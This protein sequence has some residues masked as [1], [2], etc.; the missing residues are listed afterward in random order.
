FLSKDLPYYHKMIYRYNSKPSSHGINTIMDY[1]RELIEELKEVRNLDEASVINIIP[2]LTL[3]CQP[4]APVGRD[5]IP[6]KCHTVSVHNV[7]TRPEQ[8]RSR[9]GK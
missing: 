6:S 8:F 3:R 9:F 5:P 7:D 4:H 2:E 1:G